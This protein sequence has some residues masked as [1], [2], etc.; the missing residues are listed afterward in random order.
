LTAVRVV[1]VVV[2]VVTG[3]AVVT[4]PAPGVVVTEVVEVVEAGAATA[5]AG[6]SAAMSKA[7]RA[8]RSA[9]DMNGE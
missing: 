9:R 6:T 2:L 4:E 7:G 1:E 5:E 3:M 8:R